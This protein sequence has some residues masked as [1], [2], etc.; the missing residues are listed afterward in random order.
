MVSIAHISY[1][2]SL[3]LTFLVGCL[4]ANISFSFE[5]IRPSVAPKNLGSCYRKSNRYELNSFSLSK[6][7]VP[8]SLP[9]LTLS[10]MTRRNSNNGNSFEDDTSMDYLIT[11][12]LDLADEDRPTVQDF[13]FKE[14]PREGFV[15]LPFIICGAILSFCN[16]LGLYEENIYAPLVLSSVVLGLT[17]AVLDITESKGITK[18]N[19]RRGSI[20]PK[21]LQVYAGT[22]SISVCWIALRTYP[23]ICPA[24]LPTFD[25]IL[26]PV[27][28]F[29]FAAS[30]IAPLLTL[31]SDELPEN[32]I[33]QGTQIGLVRLVRGDSTITELPRF[34]PIEKYRAAGLLVIGFVACL[35]L[36]ES[37]YLTLYGEKWWG[38]VLENYPQQG[39]LEASTALFGLIAAQCNIS[40]TRAAGYGVRPV[41]EMVKVG[42]GACLVFTV[43]PCASALYFLQSGTTFFEHYKY[44]PN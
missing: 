43:V 6:Q 32:S 19:I 1:S 15:R 44:I 33:L 42:A 37:T 35:Y 8:L 40:V 21:V 11:D 23:P 28:S 5:L 4:Y 20:D 18:N 9:L 24:W 3:A 30:L 10:A 27:T 26:G 22:Y 17:N 41:S 16:V 12:S 14:Y 39:L 31:L 38:A 29:L 7:N 25:P 2:S 13:F 34:T 36:P